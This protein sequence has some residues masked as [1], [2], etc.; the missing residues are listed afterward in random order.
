MVH[1]VILFSPEKFIAKL[2]SGKVF[3]FVFVCLVTTRTSLLDKSMSLQAYDNS[4]EWYDILLL[5]ERA[6][7]L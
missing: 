6:I 2:I 5:I 3:I 4:A 7:R 1:C